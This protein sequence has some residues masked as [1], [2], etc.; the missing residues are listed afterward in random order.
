[1]GSTIVNVDMASAWDGDEGTKWARDWQRYDRSVAGYHRRLLDAVAVSRGERVLDVGCGN[2]ETT[3][4]AARAAADSSVVGVDLSSRMLERARGLARAEGLGNIRFEHVD[5]QAHRFAPASFDVALS[6]FG[7]MFFGDPVAAFTNIASALRAGGRLVIV[8]WRGVHD[9][10]WLQC[11]FGALAVGRELPVSPVGAP[12]PFGQADPDGVQDT[13][14]AAGF[15]SVELTA[16]DEPFW[17]GADATDAFEFMRGS[18]IVGG[19]TKG[20]DDDQRSRALDALRA[21]MIEHDTGDG[22]VFGSGAWIIAARRV[23]P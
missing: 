14:N 17:M 11:I 12:G 22:V 18:G 7:T 1:M 23:S 13:L 15:D 16:V 19:M 8:A 9:N 3:R 20:L 6:R 4:A 2:G 5:A 21:T 10:E